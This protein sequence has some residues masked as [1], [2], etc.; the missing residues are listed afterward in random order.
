VSGT[1]AGL[2]PL[3]LGMVRRV[4]YHSAT[5]YVYIVIAVLLEENYYQ[6]VLRNNMAWSVACTIKIFQ[7]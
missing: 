1:G 3:T 4:F 2:E 6:D 5:A 7:S